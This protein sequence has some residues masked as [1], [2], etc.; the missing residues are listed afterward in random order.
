M[1]IISIIKNNRLVALYR[2]EVVREEAA[3]HIAATA[4][5]GNRDI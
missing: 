1:L 4:I 3:E 2:S 5:S